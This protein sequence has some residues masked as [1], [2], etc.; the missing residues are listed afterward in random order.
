MG[1]IY[2]VLKER[3]DRVRPVYPGLNVTKIGALSVQSK[4]SD[5]DRFASL[6]K[7]ILT[8]P[9]A[10]LTKHAPKKPGKPRAKKRK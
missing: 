3:V 7:R 1:S 4:S 9:K 6:A 2:I 8:T 10:E 5:F